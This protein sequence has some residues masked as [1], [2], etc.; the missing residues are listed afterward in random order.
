MIDL[1]NHVLD[2]YT[3]PCES[4]LHK[5][6]DGYITYDWRDEVLFLG[7]KGV[8]PN[9]DTIRI[10][11]G[12]T[13]VNWCSISP[14]KWAKRVIVSDTVKYIRRMAFYCAPNIETLIIGENVEKMDSDLFDPNTALQSVIFKDIE[15]WLVRFNIEG[16]E[17][18]KL[19][20]SLDNPEENVRLFKPPSD[21][22]AQDF[23][24]LCW[25]KVA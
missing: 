1:K 19:S 24:Q 21:D 10:P 13:I 15:N 12:V 4:K 6:L 17:W 25:K 18:N 23:S 22:E 8:Q 16:S 14:T 7:Y 20:T 9:D 2:I 3:E 11:E 5:D